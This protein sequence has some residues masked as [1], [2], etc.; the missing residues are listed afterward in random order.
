MDTF[1]YAGCV[2]GS[3]LDTDFRYV[4]KFWIRVFWIRLDTFGYA[5]HAFLLKKLHEL[6]GHA[7]KYLKIFKMFNDLDT[8]CKTIEKTMIAQNTI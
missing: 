1:R 2:P 8:L 4:P 3:I 6:V 7:Q 5:T